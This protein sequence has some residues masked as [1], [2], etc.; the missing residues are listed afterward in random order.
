MAGRLT[1]GIDLGGT[2]IKGAIVDENSQIVAAH[3]IETR[4]E[5]GFAKVAE[6]IAEL[7]QHLRDQMPDAEIACVGIGS[8]GPLSHDEGI[9]YRAPNLPGSENYPLVKELRDKLNLPVSL[10]NDAN[11]AAYGEFLAGAVA[12]YDS[13]VLLTLGTGVGGG[14]VLDGELLRGVFESA[15]EVGHTVIVPNGRPCPCHQKGCLERYASANAIGER[16]TE[17][18]QAG[19]SSLLTSRIESGAKI[20]SHDVLNARDAGCKLSARIW[21]EACLYLAVACVNLQHLVNPQAIVLAG[22]LINAGD[23][24][25]DPVRQHFDQQSWKIGNDRPEILLA[26]LHTDAGVIG[27]AGLAK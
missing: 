25:L 10:E 7:A 1:I 8:P 18:V 6:R 2:N 14:I 21:D 9:I 19:E 15:G 11:A 17:A 3:S 13:M 24:L 22:G 12:Q 5:Q 4:S 16:L 23:A 26:T 20:S 27:A